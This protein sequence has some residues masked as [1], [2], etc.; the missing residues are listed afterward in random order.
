MRQW[1]AAGVILLGCTSL[2]SSAGAAEA[3][4][5]SPTISTEGTLDIPAGKESATIKLSNETGTPLSVS[6]AI[7]GYDGENAPATVAGTP[8]GESPAGPCQIAPGAT[9]PVSVSRNLTATDTGEAVHAARLVI[10]A[11]GGTVRGTVIRVPIRV[12][13]STTKPLTPEPKPVEPLTPTLKKRVETW[14]IR[15]ATDIAIPLRFK[16]NSADDVEAAVKD[17]PTIGSLSVKGEHP[18]SV[19][20]DGS[21]TNTAVALL[22]VEDIGRRGEF[23]GKLDVNDEDEGGEI[24]VTL[25]VTDHPFW[26]IAMIAFGVWIAFRLAKASDLGLKVARLR[27]RLADALAR[28][29]RADQGHTNTARHELR[30][31]VLA[32]REDVRRTIDGWA[33]SGAVTLDTSSEDYKD[34]ESRM[35]ALEEAIEAWVLFPDLVRGA[36]DARQVIVAA[37]KTKTPPVGAPTEP[38]VVTSIVE[39]AKA[40]PFADLNDFEGTRTKLAVAK[41]LATEW[42]AAQARAESLRADV[43]RMQQSAQ[44]RPDDWKEDAE[45][46]NAADN[47]VSEIEQTLWTSVELADFAK[48]TEALA[49]A[50]SLV[51]QLKS[52]LDGGRRRRRVREELAPAGLDE[53]GEPDAAPRSPADVASQAARSAKGEANSL[54]WFLFVSTFVVAI[55]TG[56]VAL[57]V[58][59]PFGRLIDY[60]SAFAWGVITKGVIDGI[61]ALADRNA[62]LTKWSFIKRPRPAA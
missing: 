17:T 46:L 24:D 4:E 40:R 8:C 20:L 19:T 25:I 60:L 18:V 49:G 3:D 30:P 33:A 9:V 15:K 12:G 10:S 61:T 26:P 7:D 47:Q 62:A 43:E 32:A 52:N 14:P 36:G 2:A 23:T 31:A 29:E 38:G 5:M 21:R 45:T 34:L 50:Q 1:I 27:E 51:N 11:A 53:V 37:A 57:Y 22:E 59:K 13:G 42:P 58:D 35:Q 55:W 39:A 28:F 16:E 54:Y 56:L 44:E 48:L 6:F 41:G